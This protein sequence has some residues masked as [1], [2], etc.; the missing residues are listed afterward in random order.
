MA[1]EV[2]LSGEIRPI[3]RISQRISEAAKLGFS[4]ILIPEGNVKGIDIEKQAIEVVPVNRVEVA[5]RELFG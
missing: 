3:T 2:G 5:L 1:G 4:R